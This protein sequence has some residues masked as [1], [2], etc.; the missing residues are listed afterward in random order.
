MGGR[1]GWG[2]E[3]GRKDRVGGRMGWGKDVVGGRMGWE[4]GQGGR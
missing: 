4:E 1:E 3:W 2:G